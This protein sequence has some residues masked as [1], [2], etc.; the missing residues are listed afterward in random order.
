MSIVTKPVPG[1]VA[2]VV[3]RLRALLDAKNV[4]T[5]A[6]IDQ[7]AAARTAGLTLRDTVLVVFGDPASGTPV[8]VAAPLAAVDLPLKVV[9]WDD[10]GQSVVSYRDPVALAVEQGAPEEL[11]GPLRA[12]HVLT[13][14]LAAG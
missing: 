1:T 5:F 14:A 6:V 2:E 12:V 10:N 9:I 3:D 8:M 4:T 7:A 11:T 13:D